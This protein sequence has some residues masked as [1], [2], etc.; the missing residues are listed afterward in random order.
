[1][2]TY[3]SVGDFIDSYYRLKNKGLGFFLSRLNLSS[4]QRTKGAWNYSV[5]NNLRWWEIPAVKERLNFLKTGNPQ[6]ESAEYIYNKFISNRKNLTMLSPGCGTGFKELK[7]AKF[8]EIARLDAFDIAEKRINVAIE[9]AKE[10]GLL[11][12]NFFSADISTYDFGK[13]KYDIILF[14]SFLH[15]VKDVSGTLIKAKQALKKDGILIVDEYVGRKRFQWDDEQL[16]AANTALKQLPANLRRR[17]SGRVKSEIFRPGLI[18][19]ILSDPSEAVNSEEIIMQLNL[20]FRPVEIH[21]TGGNLLQLV[22]K[23]IEHNFADP[24][25][26]ASKALTQLFEKEDRLIANGKS[27]FLFGIYKK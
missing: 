6:T 15:H 1:M 25:E 24:T 19:M 14:D 4:R 23:D 26:E 16:E 17:T 27:D 22:L 8:K 11:N 12:T 18:R 20:L 9:T 10:L 21:L 2:R 5:K 7:F 13:E 3:I